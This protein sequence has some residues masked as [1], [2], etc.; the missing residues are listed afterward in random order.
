MRASHASLRLLLL[1]VF[2]C[3]AGAATFAWYA[4]QGALD[5]RS[6]FWESPPHDIAAGLIGHLLLIKSPWS[7]PLLLAQKLEQPGGRVVLFQDSNPAVSL[8]CKVIGARDGC[9]PEWYFL[10]YVLQGAAGAFLAWAIGVRPFVLRA[11]TIG[12]VLT[13]PAYLGRYNFG[14]INL[15]AHFVILLSIA[16]YF[17]HKRQPR[18]LW[19]IV[20]GLCVLLAAAIHPYLVIMCIAIAGAT[21]ADALFGRRPTIGTVVT[22]V[23]AFAVLMPSWMF[24]LG[25]FYEDGRSP[26]DFGHNSMN[27]ASPLVPQ[28]SWLAPW[29]TPVID[30]TGGQAEGMNYLGAGLILLLAVSLGLRW[31]NLP[32]EARKHISLLVALSGLLALALSNQ[33]YF[34][35]YHLLDIGGRL[36]ADNPLHNFRASGRFF[37]PIAYCLV[38]F[39]VLGLN[40]VWG[41]RQAAVAGLALGALS[42]QILDTQ[43]YRSGLPVASP[44]AEQAQTVM[45]LVGSA[46]RIRFAQSYHCNSYEEYFCPPD[47]QTPC[48]KRPGPDP[49]SLEDE[50]ALAAA[51]RGL[52]V[53][54]LWWGRESTARGPRRCQ[55]RLDTVLSTSLAPE[56][57]LVLLEPGIENV[58][59]LS[60]WQ[61]R[62]GTN[63]SRFSSGWVCTPSRAGS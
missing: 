61:E 45:Q 7:F 38:V 4:P 37:W 49:Q 28:K 42:V 14:H 26:A 54:N 30:A 25:Y 41:R 35:G 20:E 9:Y 59:R 1:I 43:T 60:E 24:C 58:Q 44:M 31:R 18:P 36:S 56:E 62:T 22:L 52:A 53:E 33:V 19:L 48:A 5:P 46:E 63:C 16:A 27:L 6:V 8:V 55:E 17:L 10:S 12:L 32:T 11:L 13:L 51:R 39:A 50:I 21:Y 3:L 29:D 2:G 15:T 47:T 23:A 57:A 34:L 40:R